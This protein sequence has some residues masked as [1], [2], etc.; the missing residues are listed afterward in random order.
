MDL[1]RAFEVVD[2][3]GDVFS[4]FPPGWICCYPICSLVLGHKGRCLIGLRWICRVPLYGKDGIGGNKVAEDL[5][6]IKLLE[7]VL[8][9]L[10]G[11]CNVDKLLLTT[12]DMV[13]AVLTLNFA[14]HARLAP[15]VLW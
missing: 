1:V 2:C 15:R 9:G 3:L 6:R 10:V 12:F 11:L 7:L 8:L 13:A 14:I 4:R 5:G